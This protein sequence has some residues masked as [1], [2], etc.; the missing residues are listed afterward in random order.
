MTPDVRHDWTLDE[1]E[2][3]FALPFHELAWRA[4]SLHRRHHDPGRVQL[5][6]LSNI[7]RGGCPEDCGYCPQAA[8]YHTGVK[9]E[10]LLALDAVVDQ[11]RR[12]REAGASRFCMGAAW[13]QVRDGAAFDRV[14][15]MVRE[16]NALGLEVCVTLGMLTD[17]Q[18]RRLREAGLTAYNHNIDTSP[19]YYG[20]VITTRRF[21]DRL[22]TLRSVRAAGITVCSGGIVGMG[23]GVLDRAHMLQVLANLDPHPESV[24]INQLVRAP[25]TPLADQEPI[26]PLDFLRTIAVARILMPKAMVRLAAGRLS[27]SRESRVLAYLLGANSI[28]YGEELLTTPNPTA[29]EDRAL[30]MDLGLAPLQPRPLAK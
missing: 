24:P 4:Q 29:D 8:R 13:R 1:V 16:V 11:A 19:G 7:K 30:F 27:L 28:F 22:G 12:A 10:P 21:E 17:E 15:E 6:T 20:E 5:C 25:G 23:E 9:G 26:D 18:A 2:A 14:L 3:L